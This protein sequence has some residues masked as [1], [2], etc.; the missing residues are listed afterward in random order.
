V[1]TNGKGNFSTTFYGKPGETWTVRAIWAGDADHS[2]A[3]KT[4]TATSP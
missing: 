1:T 3:R 4:V 2:S